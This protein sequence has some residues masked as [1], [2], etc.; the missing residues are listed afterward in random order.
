MTLTPESKRTLRKMERAQLMPELKTAFRQATN[1]AV[2]IVRSEIRSK[3]SQAAKRTRE[4]LR[5]QVA[6]AIKRRIG[7]SSR[8]AYVAIVSEP[9]G[10]LANLARVVE[11]EIPW[12]HPTFGHDPTMRQ[13]PMPF[14]YGTLEKLLPPSTEVK[15]RAALI[16]FERKL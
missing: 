15:V 2:P 10:G 3:P 12:D 5:S 16:K 7:F 6:M 9:H 11:G 14:F 8:R 13:E 1:T 4:S